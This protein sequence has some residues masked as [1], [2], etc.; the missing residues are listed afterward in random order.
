M[1]TPISRTVPN[2]T[3]EELL[4][5]LKPRLR[6]IL[7]RYRIPFQDAEDLVQDALLLLVRK[8]EDLRDPEAYLLTTLQF[9]CRMYWRSQGLRRQE[10]VAAERLEDLAQ[11][12]PPAQDKVVL[13]Q[14]LARLLADIPP[15]PRKLIRLR[16]GLGYTSREVAERLGAAPEAVR[17]RSLYARSLFAASISRH[18]LT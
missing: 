9:R 13:R 8:I 7:G 6:S 3:I 17:Q 5:R 14:D 10:A 1:E 4:V 2:H 16:Y 15:R 11:P 12:L 18:N